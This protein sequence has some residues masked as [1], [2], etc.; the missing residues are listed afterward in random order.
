MKQN[1]L[2]KLI[3]D[4]EQIKDVRNIAKGA[5]S[6][7]TGFLKKNDFLN[8]LF[9]M[10]LENG[11]V[12]SIPIALDIDKNDYKNLKKTEEVLLCNKNSKPIATLKN[13]EIYEYDKNSFAGNIF[14]TLDKQHPGV[15]EIYEMGEYLIGGDIELLDNTRSPF[16]KYNLTPEETKKIFQDKGWDKIVAFQTRNVPH[17]AHEFLQKSALEQVDS[18]PAGK[19][20]LFIQPIIGRKKPGDFKDE[21]ILKAYEIILEKYYP[22]N[23]IHLGILPLKMHYAGPREAIFHALIRKNFGCTH[24]IIGRDHAGVGNY[25]GSYDA[26]KIFD[27][28]SEKELGIKPIKCENVVYCNAC[29]D[30]VFENA[31]Q[32]LDERE[33]L[34]GTKMR[35]MIKQKQSLPEKFI[36]LEVSKLLINHPDPFI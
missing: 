4:E 20:G 1:N 24:I 8:V 5:Y 6:P 25:Y 13:I 23:K 28:F 16:P 18:L 12:W 11:R 2:E 29:E 9:N 10:R 14:G 3:L 32:H 26:Q 27:K 7:L 21:L 31:C 35:E 15:K 22:R 30:L 36:R 17:L 19:A 33:F 34:S